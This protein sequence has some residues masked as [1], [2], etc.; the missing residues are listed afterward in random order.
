[1]KL[2]N[3]KNNNGLVPKTFDSIFDEI[4][5]NDL[6]DRHVPSISASVNITESADEYGIEVI[7]PGLSKK[8][9]KISID[10]DVMSI[11]GSRS[12]EKEEKER[13]F[14]RKEFGFRAIKRTFHIPEDVN[15]D[16]IKVNYSNGVLTIGLPKKEEA[17]KAPVR[18][19]KIS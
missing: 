18:E 11:E 12:V 4:W 8:D 5:K 13:K 2:V 16:E 10:N 1:M 7:A 14:I 6:F 19:L 3:W 9:F 17:K 15:A